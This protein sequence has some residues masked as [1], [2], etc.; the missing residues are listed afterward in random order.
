MP[1]ESEI[2][3]DILDYLE[4]RGFLAWRNQIQGIKVNG[5]TIKNPNK[6]QPDIWAVKRGL[7]LGVEVK[8]DLGRLF[9]KQI[10]WIHLAQQFGVPI[11]VAHSVSELSETL[12]E[13]T[14]F[15]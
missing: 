3:R 4:L 11:I 13:L 15:R 6:G 7:L 5:K 12:L 8:T 2:Q 9:D 1:R 14:Q 10:E